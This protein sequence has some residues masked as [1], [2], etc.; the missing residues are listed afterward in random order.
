MTIQ[1]SLREFDEAVEQRPPL[2]IPSLRSPEHLQTL[3]KRE[4]LRSDRNVGSFCW[5]TFDIQHP[6]TGDLSLQ[7]LAYVIARRARVTDEVGWRDEKSIGVI[8]PA[9]DR[10]GADCFA[11]DVARRSE[12]WRIYPNVTIQVYPA[13]PK[14]SSNSAPKFGSSSGSEAWVTHYVPARGPFLGEP[15]SWHKR[16]TDII[17]SAVG[18]VMAS[19]ILLAAA[20]AVKFSSAGPV[21]FGQTRAGLGGRPFTIYKFRSMHLDAESRKSELSHL[22]EQDGPAFKIKNDPRVWQYKNL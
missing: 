18:L 12:E 10:E 11:A 5:V 15:I 16:L 17:G 13:P 9:T 21:F 7:R 2:R 8:L 3:L 1:T 14:T 22:N 19:P 20:L 6:G 4:R